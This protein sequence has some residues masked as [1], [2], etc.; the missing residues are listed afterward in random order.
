[1]VFHGV[2]EEGGEVLW[3]W[4]GRKPL[5]LFYSSRVMAMTISFGES[6]G[7][8]IAN[9]G[10]I[11]LILAIFLFFTGLWQSVSNQWSK[12]FGSGLWTQTIGNAKAT[13]QSVP[14]APMVQPLPTSVVPSPA[15]MPMGTTPPVVP[16]VTPAGM[17]GAYGFPPVAAATGT[18]MP[19]P[20]MTAPRA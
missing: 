13:W 5:G 2:Q 1:M 9:W 14:P 16:V 11:F 4:S 12:F 15:L 19:S 20:L 8:S 18:A 6:A 7:S 3:V 17:A 10:F